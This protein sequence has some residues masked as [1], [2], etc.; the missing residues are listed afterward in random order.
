MTKRYVSIALLGAIVLL[1]T[2]G[3]SKDEVIQIE[4][5]LAEMSE[6]D[7]A[8]QSTVEFTIPLN[9]DE[10]GVATTASGTATLAIGKSTID[11]TIELHDV[12]TSVQTASLYLGDPGE[13]DSIAATLFSG[14]Q[15]GPINGVLADGT[16]FAED[17][18]NVTLSVLVD[19]IR[20]GQAYVIVGTTAHPGGELRG[21][22]GP[23]GEARFVL[24]G[25]RVNYVVEGQIISGV[26]SAGIY[27]GRS[28]INGSLRVSLFEGGP[29]GTIN[30][31]IAADEFG[32]SDIDGLTLSQLI[33]QMRNGEAYVLVTTSGSPGGKMRGQVWL[34]F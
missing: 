6:A 25:S 14:N 5:F 1:G 26:T 17:I 21:Q 29:T 27:S 3:C 16:L 7:I 10:A 12:G 4:R 2:A 22:T 9:G 13:A 34:R 28:G 19:A 20:A 31:D 23:R 8:G 30:G 11:Y 32:S 15:P 33:E 18:Q 24:S